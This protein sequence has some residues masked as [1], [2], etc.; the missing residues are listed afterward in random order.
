MGVVIWLQVAETTMLK[1]LYV[2]N[3]KCLVNFEYR[4]QP[5]ELLIGRNGAGKSCVFDVLAY[6]RDFVQPQGPGCSLFPESSLRRPRT[7]LQQTFELEVEDCDLLARYRLVIE[8]DPHRHSARVVEETL[9]DDGP[10][11]SFLKG[12]VQLYR[13]DHSAGPTYSFNWAQSALAFVAEGP[14]NTRLCRFR[15]W[16]EAIMVLRLDPFAMRGESD[17]EDNSLELGGTNFASWYRWLQLVEPALLPALWQSLSELW[18][19]FVSLSSKPIGERYVL[20]AQFKGGAEGAVFTP[21]GGLDLGWSELSEGQR[22]MVVL[23]TLAHYIQAQRSVSWPSICL[24][25]PDNFVALA[26]VQPWLRFVNELVGQGHAQVLISSHHPEI[27]NTLGRSR[28]VVLS[29]DGSGPTRLSPFWPA[30]GASL[31]PAEIV[32]RGWENG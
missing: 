11:F 18:P 27:I 1:R 21:A 8:H 7:G 20:R 2:D 4:P 5:L 12:E 3:Y 10:L 29:R 25:E 22:A 28:A 32:A 19:D 30:D 26:E 31:P 6:L 15:R 16:V 14:S 17:R 9:E 24:D 13:D 23:Y